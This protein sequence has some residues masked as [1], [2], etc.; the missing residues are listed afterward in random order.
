M[1][2]H[3]Y[4]IGIIIVVSFSRF[5]KKR[6][7]KSFVDFVNSHR[8]GIAAQELLETNKSI[9]EICFECGFNNISNFNRIFKKKQG[10]TPGDFRNNF[11][12][13]SNVH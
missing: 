5:I 11:I 2:L 10:C 4:F 12:G 8:I 6:T 13:T 1:Q 3:H 7:G 9:S